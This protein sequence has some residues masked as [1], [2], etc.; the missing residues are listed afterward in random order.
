MYTTSYAH[1]PLGHTSIVSNPLA[2]YVHTS[3][4]ID[5]VLGLPFTHATHQVNP[6]DDSVVTFGVDEFG[7]P[8]RVISTGLLHGHEIQTFTERIAPGE[9][10]TTSHVQRNY[11]NP[12][13]AEE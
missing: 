4:V 9:T 2:P 5:P 7:E 1:G 12:W 8:I 11:L 13:E 3:E 10:V 6:Y